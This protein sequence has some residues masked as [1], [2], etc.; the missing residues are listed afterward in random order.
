MAGPSQACDGPA[1]FVLAWRAMAISREP[2]SPARRPLASRSLAGLVLLAAVV[3]AGCG[4]NK[5]E[6]E[7]S[8][9]E[10]PLAALADSGQVEAMRVVADIEVLRAG[11]IFSDSLANALTALPAS[12][13]IQL[14]EKGTLART[15]KGTDLTTLVEYT[16]TE[17]MLLKERA[18]T[19]AQVAELRRM[20]QDNIA[21]AAEMASNF[22]A[23]LP[24]SPN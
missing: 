7:R 14:D 23:K 2:V 6:K 16:A 21:A 8:V 10:R 1:G 15:G 12:E 4:P 9:F 19:D 5:V 17:P 18:V 24:Q 3:L 13:Y 20:A 11:G 22:R